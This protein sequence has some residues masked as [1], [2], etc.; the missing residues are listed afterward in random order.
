MNWKKCSMLKLLFLFFILLKISFSDLPGLSSNKKI[1]LFKLS[2]T[3]IYSNSLID[4]YIGIKSNQSLDGVNIRIELPNDIAVFQ[5]LRKG[6]YKDSPHWI[7]NNIKSYKSNKLWARIHVPEI[8]QK[9]PLRML[10]LHFTYVVPKLDWMQSIVE[11]VDD[12]EKS[13]SYHQKPDSNDVNNLP[14]TYTETH[15]IMLDFRKFHKK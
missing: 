7:L 9:F 13:F 12:K 4:V 2:H 8:N 5:P 3:E 1:E 11:S 6:K 14:H 10:K 15:Y